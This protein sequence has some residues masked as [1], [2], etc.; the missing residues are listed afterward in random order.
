MARH[1]LHSSW[2][3]SNLAGHFDKPENRA[4]YQQPT[5]NAVKHVHEARFR[6]WPARP[7]SCILFRLHL[8]Q[9]SFLT[10]TVAT[11]GRECAVLEGGL[12]PEQE[13]TVQIKEAISLQTGVHPSRIMVL[14][15]DG[16]ELLHGI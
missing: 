4:S 10:V 15:P 16:E 2:L 3:L 12:R 5:R 6:K 14:L 7:S 13:Y 8:Q 1:C 11:S 9:E